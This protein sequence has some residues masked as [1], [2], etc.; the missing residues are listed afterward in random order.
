VE[1]VFVRSGGGGRG[2]V[3]TFSTQFCVVESNPAYRNRPAA[4]YRFRTAKTARQI[5]LWIERLDFSKVAMRLRRELLSGCGTK[6]LLFPGV[7]APT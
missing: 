2:W 5:D 4:A 3:R 6:L 1:N 7:G